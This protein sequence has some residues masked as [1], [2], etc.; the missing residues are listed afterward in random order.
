MA[1]SDLNE[2]LN[3]LLDLAEMLLTKQGAF[4]PVGAIMLS[5]GEVRHVAGPSSILGAMD[6]DFTA[7][8]A[9]GAINEAMARRARHTGGATNP[10]QITSPHR[11]IGADAA[12][13]TASGEEKDS[14]RRTKRPG[15]LRALRVSASNCL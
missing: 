15:R 9:A 6:L 5:N 8:H 4:L 12:N 7:Q 3:H 11:P 13:R 1:H 10:A 2:L 14:P